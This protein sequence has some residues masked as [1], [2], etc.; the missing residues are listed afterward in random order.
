VSHISPIESKNIDILVSHFFAKNILRNV[1]KSFACRDFLN[2]L[3]IEYHDF[4]MIQLVILCTMS[5]ISPIESKNI[6]IL[7][8]QF[9]CQKILHNVKKSFA[10]MIS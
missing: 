6:D 3:K 2:I 5:H 9:L 8:S 7:V 1:K 10:F 4:Q